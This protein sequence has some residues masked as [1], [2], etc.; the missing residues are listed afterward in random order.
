[1]DWEKTHYFGACFFFVC[2]ENENW[3]FWEGFL[4]KKCILKLGMV[5]VFFSSTPNER[6][7]LRP[8]QKTPSV[9]TKEVKPILFLQGEF[10]GK[11]PN[12][13]Q[14]TQNSRTE[15]L[16][17]NISLLNSGTCRAGFGK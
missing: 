12:L 2:G 14:P 3:E 11:S 15:K 16:G 6:G 8:S 5:T 17:G 1:M 7:W 10:G 4:G 13:D 9:S